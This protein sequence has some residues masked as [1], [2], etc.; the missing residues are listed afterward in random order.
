MNLLPKPLNARTCLT[1]ETRDILP[2]QVVPLF[3]RHRCEEGWKVMMRW[4][5]TS[6][7][8]N[9][10]CNRAAKKRLAMM[11]ALMS[12]PGFERSLGFVFTSPLS[13]PHHPRPALHSVMFLYP[14]GRQRR[15]QK[16]DVA[17]RRFFSNSVT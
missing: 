1:L 14:G 9:A 11:A 6:D 12:L 4:G 17:E 5:Y 15:M 10:T 2:D 13:S 7:P 8:A 16:S 3:T